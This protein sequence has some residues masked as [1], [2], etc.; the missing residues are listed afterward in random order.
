MHAKVE[1]DAGES[2]VKNFNPDAGKPGN[3]DYKWEH[4]YL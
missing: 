1:E 2:R 3:L 4:V